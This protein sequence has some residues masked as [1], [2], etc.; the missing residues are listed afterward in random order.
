MVKAYEADP[1]GAAI[2][3]RKHLGWYAKGL[4]NAAS[5]KQRL[6]AVTNLDEIAPIFADYLAQGYEQRGAST[7]EEL[8]DEA[9]A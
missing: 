5:L 4:F 7:D 9:A 6:Y 2:E 3:F 1:R 8:L